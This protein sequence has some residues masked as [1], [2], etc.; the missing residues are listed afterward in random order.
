[1]ICNEKKYNL[2]IR[3]KSHQYQTNP[4]EIRC[5]CLTK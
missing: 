3:N 5:I 2:V 1:M 4:Y